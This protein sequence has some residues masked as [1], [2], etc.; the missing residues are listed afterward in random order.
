MLF[1]PECGKILKRK[2]TDGKEILVCENCEKEFESEARIKK[3]SKKKKKEI[4]VV[5]EKEETMP[6]VETECPKCGNDTAYF[7]TLQTRAS[8]EPA[9]KFFKCTECGHT[10]REY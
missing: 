9:T 3:E 7:W 6:K 8:D 4:R 10:W 1:C 5:E 2:K